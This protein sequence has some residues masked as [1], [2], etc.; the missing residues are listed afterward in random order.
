MNGRTIFPIK[1]VK[2]VNKKT[3]FFF[4]E[5]RFNFTWKTSLQFYVKNIP[6]TIWRPEINF[7][8]DVSMKILF[9]NII[10]KFNE[11]QRL[12]ESLN[13]SSLPAVNNSFTNWRTLFINMWFEFDCFFHK[14]LVRIEL[15]NLTHFQYVW[16]VF[17][18]LTEF[19][20]LPFQSFRE[21]YYWSPDCQDK[22]TCARTFNWHYFISSMKLIENVIANHF[23]LSYEIS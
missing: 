11:P 10:R 18:F 20:W 14:F 7:W 22:H 23:K 8:M 9:E 4:P 1:P 5:N 21:H 19:I 2:F 13:I 16:L 3:R 15:L 12:V 6:R 17:D